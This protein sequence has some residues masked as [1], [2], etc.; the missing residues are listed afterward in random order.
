MI[1]RRLRNIKGC[2]FLSESGEPFSVR[3]PSDLYRHLE[4]NKE[5]FVLFDDSNIVVQV[6]PV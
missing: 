6:V 5:Y 3:L 2:H 1:T 4:S